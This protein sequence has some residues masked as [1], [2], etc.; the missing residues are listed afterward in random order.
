[1][2]VENYNPLREEYQFYLRHNDDHMVKT[3]PT[4]ANLFLILKKVVIM[5]NIT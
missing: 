4:F 1:M 5:Y 3:D 2:L